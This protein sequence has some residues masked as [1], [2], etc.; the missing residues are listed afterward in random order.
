MPA[1]PAG[2]PFS[3]RAF[4]ILAVVLALAGHGSQ[5]QDKPPILIGLDGEFTALGSTSAQAI[6]RGI[7]VA[8]AEINDAGGLLGGRK[9]DLVIKDNRASPAR[10]VANVKAFAA[11]PNLVAVFG[12]RF[13]PV[14]VEAVKAAHP[15]QLIT[16]A[17]WS[18]ADDII[19][20][21]LAP[22]HVFR[23]GLH[24]RIAM[25]AMIDLARK[26]GATRV[27]LLLANTLGAAATWRP[28]N[29]TWPYGRPRRSS[30]RSGTT[31]RTVLEEH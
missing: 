6:E 18:S 22:N 16:L 25:P 27:G 23:I 3:F 31:G 29:V 11:T 1:T 15:A 13:S 5:G 8:M 20:N 28:P 12:G 21:G 30:R 17:A 9:L 4:K 7:R 26:R 2:G 10:G 19:E 24:D 14:V